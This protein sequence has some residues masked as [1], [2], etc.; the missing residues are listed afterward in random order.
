MLKI[1]LGYTKTKEAAYISADNVIDVLDRALTKAGVGVIY[2]KD[3]EPSIT[4]AS[5][6]PIGIDSTSEICD[7]EIAEYLDTSFIIK[8]LN[9]A[10][11]DGMVAMSA[12]YI[13][14]DIP[15]ISESAYASVFEIVPEY[16]I[17]KMNNRQIMDLRK[18]YREKLNE[19]M[20]EEKLLV[21]VKSGT[22]NERID[23]K[24]NILEF[25]IS[26]NDGL[27][28]TVE[29]DTKYIF[30]PSYIMDGFI[31]YIDRVFKYSIRRTKILY[32]W[33]RRGYVKSID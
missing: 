2:T 26:I 17:E 29:T 14:M 9:S 23:I 16:N 1:R 3:M 25:S 12:E 32:K 22:R 13:T 18:W 30:N 27:H 15:S 28:V 7:V 31:E 4:I 33:Y 21:L 10:L 11:P 19:Y 24:P 6:L 8:S 5:P 20:N